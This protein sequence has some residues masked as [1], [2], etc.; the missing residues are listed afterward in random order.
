MK[1]LGP[2]HRLQE[3][4]T[5]TYGRLY[6]AQNVDTGRT[7]LVRVFAPGEETY[8]RLKHSGFPDPEKTFDARVDAAVTQAKTLSGGRYFAT[9]GETGVTP[10]GH[11]F[12][13]YEKIAATLEMQ[14]GP[15]VAISKKLTRYKGLKAPKPLAPARALYIGGQLLEAITELHSMRRLH[16]CVM[17]SS[18]ALS[19]DGDIQ[20]IDFG[21]APVLASDNDVGQEQILP[22]LADDQQQLGAKTTMLSEVFSTGATLRRILMGADWQSDTAPD[23]LIENYGPHFFA[24]TAQAMDRSGQDKY[25]RIAD[26]LA[27]F[28]EEVVA[29]ERKHN[30]SVTDAKPIF[31]GDGPDEIEVAAALGPDGPD[32]LSVTTTLSPSQ[33]SEERTSNDDELIASLGLSGTK[34][35]GFARFRLPAIIAGVASIMLLAAGIWFFGREQTPDDLAFRAARDDG[36]MQALTSY[37]E[38]WPEGTHRDEVQALIE[39][40][41]SAQERAKR[42]AAFKVDDDAWAAALA[43]GSNEAITTYLANYPDGRHVR[44]AGD[45]LER[46]AYRVA[47]GSEDFFAVED[48]LNRYPA[49]DYRNDLDD[50]SWLLAKDTDTVEALQ[51]YISLYPTGGHVEEARALMDDIRERR[52]AERALADQR[53]WLKAQTDNTLEAYESYLETFEKGAYRVEAEA[54]RFE[55]QRERRLAEARAALIRQHQQELVRLGYRN[56]DLNG[57]LD[58]DTS[59]AITAFNT[60]SGRTTGVNIGDQLLAA[61]RSA[62]S[63]PLPEPFAR[64]RDCDACPEMMVLPAGQFQMGSPETEV[65]RSDDEGPTIAIRLS[66]PFAISIAEITRSEWRACVAASICR[67]LNLNGVNIE[68]DV[69]PMTEVPFRDAEAFVRWLNTQTGHRYRLPTEAEWEYAARAGSSTAFSFGSSLRTACRFSNNDELVAPPADAGWM[70]QPCQDGYGDVAAVRSFEP[71]PFGLFDMHGNAEEWTSDCW[72]SGLIGQAQDGSAYTINGP[73]PC[74]SRVVKG[75]SYLLAATNAR[76]AARRG[77]QAIAGPDGLGPRGVGIRIVRDL[78]S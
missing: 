21:L 12:C 10:D 71:N 23:R 19:P 34:P 43:D 22:Y 7:A 16:R 1:K 48:F 57:R 72:R 15:D 64:F 27:D 9:V 5:D 14:I 66:V 60:W 42:L 50:R 65:G 26:M 37:L 45:A 11:V 31:S 74:G 32:T 17:P 46:N 6:A 2:Y 41:A 73:V 52:L 54:A 68:E 40:F 62:Q 25:I 59:A 35:A 38:D 49:S 63:K 75:G 69:R 24:F 44:D 47:L 70:M 39:G 33:D 13:G 4:R 76:S 78:T 53:A 58:P 18:I 3:L 67:A 56:I 51:T 36:T 29:W 61:L 77:L 8:V 20:L 55:R 28:E 30:T